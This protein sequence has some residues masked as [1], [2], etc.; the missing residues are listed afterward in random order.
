MHIIAHLL[1][2]LQKK[3]PAIRKHKAG[4]LSVTKNKLMNSE[5]GQTNLALGIKLSKMGSEVPDQ[6][7]LAEFDK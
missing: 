4:S 3:V 6:K 1:Y 7:K 5:I 2:L